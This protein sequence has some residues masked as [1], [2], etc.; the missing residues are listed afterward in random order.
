[1]VVAPSGMAD[2]GAQLFHFTT[3]RMDVVEEHDCEPTCP[4]SHGLV[5]AGDGAPLVTAQH[6]AAEAARAARSVPRPGATTS[7]SPPRVRK[8][9]ILLRIKKFLLFRR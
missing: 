8:G 3:G 7:D 5:A 9:S 4:Y 2:V 1:M 6:R